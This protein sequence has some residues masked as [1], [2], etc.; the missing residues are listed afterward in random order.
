M[1]WLLFGTKGW[2]GT[3]VQQLLHSVGETVLECNDHF[4]SYQEVWECLSFY[5]P[6][7]IVCAVGRTY[8]PGFTTIDYLEQ[9]GKLEENLISN[10]LVPTWIAQAAKNIPMLY[11]GT[12]CIY[13]STESKKVF[14]ESDVPNFTGSSYSTVK[15]ITDRLMSGFPHVL[16]ARIRMPI[17]EDSHPRDF[18]T[19]IL[20]YSKI[21]SIRNSMTVLPDIL[22]LLIAFLEEGRFF[23]T[24]NAVNPGVTDHQWILEKYKEITGNQHEY[25]LESFEA[26]SQ[27]LKSKR[28][29]NEL[30]TTV[31]QGW[32]AFLSGNTA[33]KYSLP[34]TI[35]TLQESIE[36]I[37]NTRNRK[38]Q[39]V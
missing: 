1:R 26:Q 7:R 5:H 2:I 3:Q 9:P 16:N 37:L 22:P 28:S 19:K 21:T 34:L 27:R 25:E 4:T 20:T 13:E 6:D 15:G 39:D 14:K 8:G 32:R 17:S 18:I 30:D 31:L 11:F 35:P 10:L 36:H 24:V 38:E 33:A 12:G 29:N 23:G